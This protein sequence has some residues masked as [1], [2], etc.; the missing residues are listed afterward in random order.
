MPKKEFEAFTRLDASDVNTFLMDQSVMTFGSATARDAA[1][2][3]PVEGQVT[4]LTDIDSLTVYNGTQWVTNRPVMSFAG[5]AARGSAI[6]SPVTGMTT[7]LED[8]KDLQIY[9]GSAYSS[10]FG[11]TL[12]KKQAIGTTV[13]SVVVTDAFSATYDSY[14]ILISGGVGSTTA[15]LQLQ[16]G[17]ATTAYYQSIN[18]IGFGGASSISAVSNGAQFTRIGFVTANLIDLDCVLRNPFLTRETLINSFYVDSRTNG[19]SGVAGGYLNNS[20]SYTGFTISPSS[21]TLTGGTIY[22][23]GYRKN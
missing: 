17:A 18:L 6:P 15:L 3:T 16:I 19:E 23:Y 13:S 12:V 2:D 7:Y 8:S 9:D 10:P 21:G 5:T 11:L 14:R 4:Y 22:V 20:T 1:I